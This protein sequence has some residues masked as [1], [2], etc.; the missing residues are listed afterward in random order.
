VDTQPVLGSV[1]ATA[2]A[3]VR[4]VNV[5]RNVATRDTTIRNERVVV[6]RN[7]KISKPLKFL[8]NSRVRPWVKFELGQSP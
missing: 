1:G 5:V 4:I 3:G 7:F 6:L 8:V 2:E